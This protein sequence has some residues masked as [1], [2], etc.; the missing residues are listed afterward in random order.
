MIVA[1]VEIVVTR[2]RMPVYW[3]N[4]ITVGLMVLVVVCLITVW[5]AWPNRSNR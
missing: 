4:L 3:W 5:L 1:A 2:D